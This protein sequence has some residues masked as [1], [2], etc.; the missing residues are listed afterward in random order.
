[1]TDATRRANLNEYTK[2][3]EPSRRLTPAQFRVVAHLYRDELD[4]A[5]IAERLRISVRTVRMHI[6][7]VANW[8][9]GHGFPAWKV[10]RYAER[11][12]EHGY[13]EAA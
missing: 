12:L 1:M 5:M 8:L 13:D 4:Y 9:P 10:L 2:P 7:D 11:L 6:D 3:W